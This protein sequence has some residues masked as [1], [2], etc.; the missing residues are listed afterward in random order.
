MGFYVYFMRLGRSL[1][2]WGTVSTSP[3]LLVGSGPSVEG[4]H[5][6]E[7]EKRNMYH[8]SFPEIEGIFSHGL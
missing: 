1:L 7:M 5:G 4:L 2:I 8:P 3:E 6:I